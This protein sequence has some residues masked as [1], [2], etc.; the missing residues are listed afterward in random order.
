MIEASPASSRWGVLA[1][2]MLTGIV[3]QVLWITFSPIDS[4]AS[5]VFGVSVGDVG[6]LSAVYL[7]VYVIM[8]IPAG[9]VIDS[10]GFRR[11]VLLG[12]ALL[13]FSGVT[14]SLSSSFPVVLALQ[15]VGGLGQ[16]FILNSISKL[17]RAWFPEREAALATGI[18]TLSLFIG[19]L[20]G[21]GLTPSLVGM[22]GFVPALLAYGGLSLLALLAFYVLGKER[23]K[24]VEA[25]ERIT[26][27]RIL[28]VLRNR[29]IIV[30]SF[31]FFVGLGIFN[32]VATWI[33]PLL[34]TKDVG[35][36]LAGPLG[37]LLIIGG[38]IGSVVIPALADRY[39][40]L[41]RPLLICL[42]ASGVLWYLLGVLSGTF[43]IAVVLLTLGFFFVSALPLGL[44][45]SARSVEGRAAGV[46]NA[47]VWEFSQVGGLVLILAYEVVSA[48]S[49]WGLLFFLSSAL[50]LVSLVSAL[51]LRSK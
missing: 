46:A 8:S 32:A 42:A 33:Q 16:P 40:T 41:K 48:S 10:F 31:L 39:H 44:E 23:K 26:V 3:S 15:A 12:A 11:A 18:G 7:L 51:F 35:A 20:I 22:L 2:Y 5:N 27:T 1:A 45:L 25:E 14:R 34:A 21:L 38:V 29:N 17:V 47:V 28:N 13:A 50:T 4:Q 37:S 19:I 49:G 30:L 6:L 43:L 36:D 24:D 9:Y